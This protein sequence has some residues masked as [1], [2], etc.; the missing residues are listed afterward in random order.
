MLML[1]LK[2]LSLIQRQRVQTESTC[3]SFL[4]DNN[5][6]LPRVSLTLFNYFKCFSRATV[7]QRQTSVGGFS[8]RVVLCC[9]RRRSCIFIRRDVV[10]CKNKT[11]TTKKHKKNTNCLLSSCLAQKVYIS[12]PFIK[13]E[14]G[15][16]KLFIY[17]AN[18]NLEQTK[19]GT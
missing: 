7:R 9:V 10:Q 5:L 3:L 14:K 18:E 12:L 15:G 1:S 11:T 4:R 16:K 13:C 19:E 2:H 17:L 6:P 8:C